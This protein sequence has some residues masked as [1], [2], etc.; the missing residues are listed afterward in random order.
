MHRQVALLSALAAFARAQQAGSLTPETHPPLTW[1]ECTADGCTPVEGSIV[2]DS[3]WRWV[4][5]V[6]GSENCYEGN[7]WNEALCSDNVACAENCAL[8]GVD[9]STTYG[10]TTEG[11]SLTLSY[12]TEHEYGTNV[13]S[14]VYLMEDDSNYKMFNLLNKEFTFDVDVSNIGCG[15][16]GALYFVSM[17]PDGGMARFPGNTAGAAY[18]T[19]YC[20]SQCARDIKF[21]NGEVRCPLLHG[22]LL[23]ILGPTGQR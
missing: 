4:H 21:I 16:N 5:D 8:E 1:E 3:N 11:S 14:R 10:I 19:G 15:L 6:D 2:L 20:D 12:V 23:L 13:G 17:D 9:Y 7:T 22:R 18:G